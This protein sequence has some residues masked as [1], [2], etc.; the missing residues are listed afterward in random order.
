MG[1]V[2]GMPNGPKGTES[3]TDIYHRT[4]ERMGGSTI[5][6]TFRLSLNFKDKTWEFG[7]RSYMSRYLPLETKDKVVL[8]KKFFELEWRREKLT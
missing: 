5:V 7:V 8:G 3:S 4:Q 6:L 1:K 2:G